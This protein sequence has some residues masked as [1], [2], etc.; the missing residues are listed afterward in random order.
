[1]GRLERGKSSRLIE[2]LGP[3]MFEALIARTVCVERKEEREPAMENRPKQIASNQSDAQPEQ[4]RPDQVEGSGGMEPP[5]HPTSSSE[6]EAS[7][8]TSAP[9]GEEPAASSLTEEASQKESA[10]AAEEEQIEVSKKEWEALK[11]QAEQVPVLKD[12]WLRAAAEADNLRKRFAR[13]REELRQYAAETVLRNFL[14]V[15][16]SLEM[17]LQMIDQHQHIDAIRQGLAMIQQQLKNAFRELG[18]EEIDA[19]GQMFDHNL[20]EAVQTIETDEV[21]EGQVV[22]QLRKGYRLRGRLLRPASVI[23]AK[24]PE[25]KEQPSPAQDS[26]TEPSEA[27]TEE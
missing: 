2:P 21:P 20:H 22:Q 18:V 23:V 14:P 10:P 16:D 3:C 13:E 8:S 4:N 12:R 26:Q 7:E 27:P 11:E 9:V 19:T 5:S 25:S 24:R 1:M 15:L 6:A 17:A